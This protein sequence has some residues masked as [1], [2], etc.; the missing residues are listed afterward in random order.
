M[1]RS[2]GGLWENRKHRA[3]G[4]RNNRITFSQEYPRVSRPG[5]PPNGMAIGRAV[6]DDIATREAHRAPINS[7]PFRR[8][9]DGL[10]GRGRRA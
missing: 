8:V 3:F 10:S 6:H 2:L 5:Q 7:I 1:L 9:Q 4:E